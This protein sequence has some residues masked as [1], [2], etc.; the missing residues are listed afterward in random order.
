MKII[1]DD[2][3]IQRALDKRSA[4]V[5]NRQISPTAMGYQVAPRST[6]SSGSAQLA[7]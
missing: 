4:L 5:V 3:A 1:I 7:C 2:A 6:Q